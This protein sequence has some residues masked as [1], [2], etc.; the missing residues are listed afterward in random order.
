MGG[1]AAVLTYLQTIIEYK[2][3]SNGS[4]RFGCDSDNVVNVGLRQQHDPNSVAEHYDLVRRCHEPREAM[5]PV[6]LIPMYVK[7]QTDN[8]CINREYGMITLLL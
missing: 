1:A 8:V 6:N 4:V 7:R 2:M 5:K 3:I